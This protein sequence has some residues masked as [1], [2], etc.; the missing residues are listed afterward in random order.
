MLA[1]HIIISGKVQGVFFRRNTKLKAEE[2]DLHGWVKNTS[3]NKVEIFV[4]GNKKNLIIFCDWCMQGPPK[5]Q[6][7]NVDVTETKPDNNITDFVIV[8][9]D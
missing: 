5:A 1:R 8:Y 4:Q 3:D 6:V 7:K 9:E 2:L